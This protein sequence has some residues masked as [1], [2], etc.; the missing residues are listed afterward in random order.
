M[1]QVNISVIPPNMNAIAL[2]GMTDTL[3]LTH[4][5]IETAT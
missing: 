5:K 4:Q 2:V 1:K 3:I